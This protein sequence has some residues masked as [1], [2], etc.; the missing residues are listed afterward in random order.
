MAGGWSSRPARGQKARERKGEA[1][2]CGGFPTEDGAQ[3]G[4]AG[5]QLT[6]LLH[7][8]K[9]S[10]STTTTPSP[11]KS[12]LPILS[13]IRR[14]QQTA[15]ASI[16]RPPSLAIRNS[17]DSASCSLLALSALYLPGPARRLEPPDTPFPPPR[18]IPSGRP[19]SRAPVIVL[20]RVS[21]LSLPFLLSRSSLTCVRP[22][23]SIAEKLRIASSPPESITHPLPPLSN[24]LRLQLASRLTSNINHPI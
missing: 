11:S 16:P 6:D 20:D 3:S 10:L 24:S 4:L 23:S 8:A 17:S 18:V 7:S 21:N 9:P 5:V 19:A 15:P 14:Q 2:G 12:L 13:S 1:G 22:T